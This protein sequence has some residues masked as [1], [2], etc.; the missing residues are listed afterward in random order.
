MVSFSTVEYI[1]TV[2]GLSFEDMV[3]VQQNTIFSFSMTARVAVSTHIV[4]LPMNVFLKECEESNSPTPE[5]LTFLLD[6][7]FF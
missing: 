5:K 1:P 4:L 3:G 6:W 2:F 7:N